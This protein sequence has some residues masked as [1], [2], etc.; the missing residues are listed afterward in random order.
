MSVVSVS[1]NTARRRAWRGRAS[2]RGLRDGATGEGG[3]RGRNQACSKCIVA[4]LAGL[5]KDVWDTWWTLALLVCLL[6][7]C[8]VPLAYASPSVEVSENL[9]GYENGEYYYGRVVVD[10]PNQY[11]A[12]LTL[13]GEYKSLIQIDSDM[14]ALLSNEDTGGRFYELTQL[15]EHIGTNKSGTAVNYPQWL[16]IDNS[17]G[18]AYIDGLNGVYGYDRNWACVC[19][20]ALVDGAKAD[21][22]A[23]LSG[24]NVGGD[25]GGDSG[26][27]DGEE[28]YMEVVDEST[29]H[30]V[31][32]VNPS[33]YG[34]PYTL[35]G[36]QYSF[37]NNED[38]LNSGSGVNKTL[39]T[40]VDLTV[41]A[42]VDGTNFEVMSD[43]IIYADMLSSVSMNV[44][45]ANKELE[46]EEYAYNEYTKYRYKNSTGDVVTGHR[47]GSAYFSNNVI[48]RI[49]GDTIYVTCDYTSKNIYGLSISN[50]AYIYD[51]T[52]VMYSCG[53]GSSGD[54]GSDGGSGSSVAGSSMVLGVCRYNTNFSFRYGGSDVWLDNAQGQPLSPD[55]MTL[56]LPSKVTDEIGQHEGYKL[57]CGLSHSNDCFMFYLVPNESM[58][59]WEQTTWTGGTSQKPT[60]ITWTG[61]QTYWELRN[62]YTPWPDDWPSNGIYILKDSDITGKW[63]EATANGGISVSPR[64]VYWSDKV[65]IVT[66]PQSN[67]PDDDTPKK[68]DP[69]PPKVTEPTPPTTPNPRNPTVDVEPDPPTVEPDPPVTP[70]VIT[71]VSEPT[72]T[73]P[74]DYTPWLRAI[75]QVLNDIYDYMY[76][77]A[78]WLD[79]VLEDHCYHLREQMY[80]C[81]VY[82]ADS[83]ERSINIGVGSIN[84]NMKTYAEYIVN[85]NY[86]LLED[87]HKYLAE[88]AQW[89]VENLSWSYGGT[90]TDTE[91]LETWLR[92]IYY[93]LGSGSVDTRPVDPVTDYERYV[94][95][96]G[97][98]FDDVSIDLG[99][100]HIGDLS[101]DIETLE[102]TW[103]FS[104]PWDLMAVMALLSAEPVTPAITWVIPAT[105]WYDE[106]SLQIDATWL[107][108][109]MPAV[110][111]VEM[112]AF[113]VFVLVHTRDL[114]GMLDD[115]LEGVL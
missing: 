104:V 59:T 8:L 12:T 13:I 91:G 44:R 31:L 6:Q 107:D 101:D 15:W 83:F 106:I 1:A 89:L 94:Q 56:K 84:D 110:R 72:N 30:G 112:M 22:L 79:G 14:Y 41:H 93:K 81:S 36:V 65:N 48:D 18:D 113:V 57:Y 27:V 29:L 53:N 98:L 28:G 16:A 61:E 111:S 39:I 68:P 114:F 7:I 66:P 43:E 17:Y 24:E 97:S 40:K 21:F 19:T 35:D 86:D 58:V 75:L 2:G 87:H 54:G 92:K 78:V 95:W 77:L 62:P 82:E 64:T 4:V 102:H 55:N 25:D 108:G 70:P 109:V 67:W 38:A 20:N 115:V 71:I 46:K 45:S 74:Q 63:V 76:T 105:D 90:T 34:I 47:L 96:L 9:A 33:G 5:S 10:A 100:I 99:G 69:T 52:T 37:Y 103:P 23:V 88:L 80:N 42:T 51:V 49:V 3:Q 60:G 85:G 26:N 73:T 11:I 50:D 32:A